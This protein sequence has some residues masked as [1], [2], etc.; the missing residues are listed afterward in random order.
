M[1]KVPDSYYPMLSKIESNDRLYAK[2]STS[3]GSGLYQFLRATWISHGGKWGSDMT[4]PFGGLKP[5]ACEQ[6]TRVKDLTENN[7]KVLEKGGLELNKATLYAA[8]FLGAGMAVRLLMSDVKASAEKI[9]GPDATKANPTILKGKTVGQFMTWLK[10][11][12]GD[13]AR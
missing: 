3:T 4:Q 8:H 6:L 11:K 13:W 12:T 5:D 10:Q 9:A 7:A 1:S 2:A